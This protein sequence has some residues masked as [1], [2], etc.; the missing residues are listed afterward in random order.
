MK[1]LSKLSLGALCLVVAN[2]GVFLGFNLMN[3]DSDLLS[4]LGILLVLVS[5]I[6]PL[7]LIL[8]LIHHKEKQT[9]ENQ[10]VSS[11]RTGGAGT[12]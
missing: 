10:D 4:Y 6:G 9:H 1:L 11:G 7:W 2:R 12:F 3:Q 8:R 5:I